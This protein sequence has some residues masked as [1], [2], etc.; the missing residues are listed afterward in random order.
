MRLFR[1]L[2]VGGATLVAAGA[3]Y[4]FQEGM[5]AMPMIK[6][7][8]EH[9]I[10]EQLAGEWDATMKMDFPGVQPSK[11]TMSTKLG[12]NGLWLVG[13]YKT[14]NFMGSPFTGHA[15]TGYDPEKGKYV[16]TW[17]DSMTMA[18]GVQEG[19]Y[20]AATKTL[21]MESKGL[22]P[23]SGEEVTMKMVTKVQDKDHHTFEMYSPGPDGSDMLA[24]TIEYVRKK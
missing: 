2:L 12:M 18:L 22:D 24:L 23:M 15:L 5:P 13:D 17:I 6:P 19:T 7:T 11:G 3:L 10:L 16:G 14:D 20:D 4:A 1:T 8:A 21:T 9:A